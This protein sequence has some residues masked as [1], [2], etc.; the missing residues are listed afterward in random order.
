MLKRV[1]L[2]LA[3]V[4]VL[5]LGIWWYTRPDPVPVV[6]GTVDRGRVER[7]VANTRAGT[8]NACRRAKLAPQAGGQ[9]AALPVREGDRV[10]A[11]EVLLELWSED[12]AAQTRVTVE[13]ARGAVLR[14]E[15]VCESWSVAARDA[16]R[17]RKL[18]RDGLLPFD[19]LDRAESA[20]KTL[21]SACEGARS[22]VQRSQAAVA[23][24]RATQKR[25]VL[26]APF[27]GV[28][29]RITGEVGEFTTP[30]PPG[31]PTPPAV[32]LIDDS[33]L[34]VT[35]PIDEVDVARVRVEQRASITI[36]AIPGRRFPGRVR[37]VAP[38]VVDFEKQARTVDVEVEFLN[39]EDVKGL[40]VGYSADAE[41]ILDVRENAL[42]VP[43]HALLEGNRVLVLNDDIVH[44]RKL[45][46]GIANWQFTEVVSGLREGEK[47]IVSVERK[48]V[49]AGARA[50]AEK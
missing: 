40:L 46:T 25:T 39:P 42:R 45:Q 43:T 29:A 4:S 22:D 38:Y 10:R 14:A 37:R 24:A 31:I 2:L 7:S 47:V 44:E 50:V 33:C 28:V 13:Q 3:G 19:Q 21:R 36:D 27:A 1:L 6:L 15:E 32:D 8:V 23:A 35:A 41:I 17:A 34:Y 12:S 30:S 9:I 48:G 20:A 16:D 5:A 18:H 11:G 26:R 49:V